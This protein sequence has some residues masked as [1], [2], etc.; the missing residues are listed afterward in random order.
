MATL[1]IGKLAKPHKIIK[2]KKFPILSG[3]WIAR[4]QVVL[5]PISP[6]HNYYSIKT[7]GWLKKQ[8]P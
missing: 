3:E 1:K 8:T 5:W 4:F 7:I 2:N 6:E